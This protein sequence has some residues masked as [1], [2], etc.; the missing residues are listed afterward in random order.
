MSINTGEF[1]TPTK[2]SII[3]DSSVFGLFFFVFFWGGA[4]VFLSDKS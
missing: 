4:G 1:K 3:P 2:L